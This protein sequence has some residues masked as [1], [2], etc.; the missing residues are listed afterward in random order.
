VT[1]TSCV[2]KNG[3]LTGESGLPALVETILAA[4]DRLQTRQGA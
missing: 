3:D 2:E 4:V 1:E